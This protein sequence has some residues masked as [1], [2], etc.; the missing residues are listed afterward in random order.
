MCVV[1][2]QTGT[3]Y[4]YIYIEICSMEFIVMRKKPKKVESLKF[5]DAFTI[6]KKILVISCINT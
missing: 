6:E 3:V 4:N 1:F 2:E 5:F